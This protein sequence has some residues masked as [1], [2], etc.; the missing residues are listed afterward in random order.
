MR[1]ALVLSLVTLCVVSSCT[2]S[3]YI[4]SRFVAEGRG[5]C[6]CMDGRIFVGVGGGSASADACNRGPTG[7]NQR[8][9]ADNI[10]TSTSNFQIFKKLVILVYKGSQ[11]QGKK[12]VLFTLFTLNPHFFSVSVNYKYIALSTTYDFVHT[13]HSFF[14]LLIKSFVST[15]NKV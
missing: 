6:R 14:T 3:T 11:K 5:F 1:R 2:I 8:Q 12:G 4:L 10:P 15:P 9:V 13:I 7:G